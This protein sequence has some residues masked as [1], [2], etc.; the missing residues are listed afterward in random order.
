MCAAC[1]RGARARRAARAAHARRARG[2][3]PRCPGHL[4]AY[5]EEASVEYQQYLVTKSYLE[6]VGT[7]GYKVS[8]RGLQ[9][10]QY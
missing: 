3:S 5:R 8:K 10:L 1:G 7:S 9:V 2:A 6:A 4:G